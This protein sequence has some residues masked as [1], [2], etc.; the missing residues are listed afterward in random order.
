MAGREIS[1]EELFAMV[2]ERPTREVAKKL[3]VSDVTIG[4][5]CARL[6]V[7]K[8]RRGYWARVHSGQTPRRPPLGAFREEVEHHRQEVAR[9]R[10]AEALTRLQQQFYAVALSDLQRRGIDVA[11]AKARGGRLPE[12]NP[13]LAAQL[14]LLIQN[15]GREWVEQGKIP[16]RWVHSVEN[17]A[18][19]LVGRLL[20]FARAQVLV[21]QSEHKKGS[22]RESGPVVFVRLTVPLQERIAAL[23]RIIREQRL[24]YVVMPLVAADHAWS[25]R[26]LYE[27]AA[28]LFLESTLCISATEIWVESLRRAW[29]EEDPP[30]RFTTTRKA[31]LAIMPIDYMPV[32]EAALPPLVTR[33]ATV[34]YQKRLQALM[35]ADRVHDMI[36]QAAYDMERTVPDEKLALAERIWFGEERPFLSARQAWKRLEDELARWQ[37]QLEAE[38]SALARSILGIE[39]GDIVT[40]GKADRLLRISVTGVTLYSGEEDVTFVVDGTRFRKDG[41]LGKLRDTFSLH[42]E[43]EKKATS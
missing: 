35:E 10:V 15:L 1:R 3:G 13:D 32:R 41:T 26:H 19:N 25:A 43:G 31:L 34:P 17:S 33:A 23:V 37:L 36:S 4:K 16:T 30:E 27:P 8:P 20:P 22:Y 7:P 6:Q 9:A 42:F 11:A 2:W 24:Q 5:L 21:F 40:A 28:R 12:L 39:V 14:L 29:R 38:R 18:T